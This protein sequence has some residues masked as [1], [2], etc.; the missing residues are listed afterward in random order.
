LGKRHPNTLTV[1]ENLDYV[2][3]LIAK[4]EKEK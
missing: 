4:Q 1:K 3:Q 2:T